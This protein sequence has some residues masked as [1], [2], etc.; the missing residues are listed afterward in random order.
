MLH[1][2]SLIARLRT[3]VFTLV[4]AVA[5]LIPA[6]LTPPPAAASR[7]ALPLAF[8][9][10]NHAI[11]TPAFIRAFQAQGG[12]A[13]FGYPISD[14]TTEGGRRVQ[15][16]ER[17]R[18]AFH[19]ERAGTRAEV[20]VT[21]TRALTA[22]EDRL[23][24]QV[25]AART[26]AG[27]RPVVLD[28]A[29]ITLARDRSSDMAHRRYFDHHTPDGKTF[30]DI[31]RMRQV[32]FYMAGEII[33]QNNYPAAQSE[34]Q[35]FQAYMGSHDHHD[36]IMMGNWKTAGVGVAMDSNGMYYY[37]VLFSQPTR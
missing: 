19:P 23:L 20:Q 25:N 37:T 5:V 18:F 1:T 9:T 7:A 14:E 11:R 21:M 31:L 32:P 8:S 34:D 33:A 3:A 30:L 4:L 27:R 15:Y 17:A 36:I 16:F 29:L 6:L 12:V 28:K 13:A 22:G 35:A 2:L 10:T 26:Q 24:A